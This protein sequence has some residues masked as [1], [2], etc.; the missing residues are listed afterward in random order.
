MIWRAN[1]W[2]R[3]PSTVT[4]TPGKGHCSLPALDQDSVSLFRA[5]TV[6]ASAVL[7]LSNVIQS[8]VSTERAAAAAQRSPL[9]VMTTFWRSL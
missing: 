2:L 4:M 7:V 6:P 5:L 9:T 1:T 3:E 8:C